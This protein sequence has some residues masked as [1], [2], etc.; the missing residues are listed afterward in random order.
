MLIGIPKE[1][2]PNENRVSIVPENVK[3][4]IQLGAE[5]L[6]E[7]NIGLNAGFSD[8]SYKDAGAEDHFKPE[9]SFKNS[10]IVL[11]LRKPPISE[12]AELKKN[13][14][15]ISFLDPFNESEVDRSIQK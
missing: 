1:I 15:H 2:S 14:I 8:K 7:P 11:R 9:R 13:S 6:I 12:I 10:D 5:I 4:L 3:K